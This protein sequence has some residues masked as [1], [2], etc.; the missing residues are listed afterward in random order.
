MFCMDSNGSLQ[1]DLYIK[2][3]DSKSYLHFGSAHP[4]HV[5]SGIVYSQCLRLRRIINSQIRLEQ[6]VKN[7]SE[8]FIKCGYPKPMVKN[9]SDKVL[10]SPRILVKPQQ[11]IID[12]RQEVVVNKIKVVTTFGTDGDIIKAIRNAEP[13]LLATRSF[14]KMSKPL[15]SFVKKPAPSI[16]YKLAIVKKIA[17]ESQC[18]GTSKCGWPRCQCDNLQFPI[19][20]LMV[21]ILGYL[22]GIVIQ[23][24]LFI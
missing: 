19:L 15:F 5:Y 22:K 1:T 7:L 24:I 2:P 10:K 9:I 4:N 13:K 21:L 18:V 6:K 17:L 23:E 3:T 14:S 16:G 12:Q 11:P 8:A 20:L